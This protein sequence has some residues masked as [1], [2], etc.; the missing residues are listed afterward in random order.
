MTDVL[1]DSNKKKLYFRIPKKDHRDAEW[2]IIRMY[3]A[4][5]DCNPEILMYDEDKEC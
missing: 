1:S 2:L 5:D 4:L 3:I